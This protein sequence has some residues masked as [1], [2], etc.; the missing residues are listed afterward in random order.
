VY[1][2]ERGLKNGQKIT[3]DDDLKALLNPP[4]GVEITYLNI[5]RYMKNHYIK[6]TGGPVDT[7]VDAP[8]ETPGADTKVK[9][10][11]T[12]RPSVKKS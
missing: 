5:Q 4:E 7:P 9:M 1:A 8:P 6:D 10:T 3:L 2:S 11:K 12:G